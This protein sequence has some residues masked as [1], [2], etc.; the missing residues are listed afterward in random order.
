MSDSN[1]EI[2]RVTTG[3]EGLDVITRGGLPAGRV[4]L[5]SGGTGAGK[6]VLCGQ[7]IAVGARTGNPGIYVT[8]EEPT[9][10]LVRNFDALG[11][12]MSGLLDEGKV[13]FVDASP[14]VGM[15]TQTTGG[16]DLSGLL[17]RVKAAADEI[18]AERVAL[19]STSAL[20]SQLGQPEALRTSLHHLSNALSEGGITTVMTS[21]QSGGDLSRFGLEEF[22]SDNVLLLTGAQPGGQRRTIQVIKMRGADHLEGPFPL[23]IRG[24]RGMHVITLASAR[25]HKRIG[26]HRVGTGSSGVDEMLNGGLPQGAILLVSGATGTGKTLVATH[27]TA[28]G[29]DNDDRTLFLSYEESPDQLISNASGWGYDFEGAIDSDKLRMISEYPEAATLEDHLV[30]ITELIDDW[31]PDRLVV[32]TLSALE[33]IGTGEGFREFLIGL[34]AAIRESGITALLTSHSP[35]MGGVGVTESHVSAVT[36]AIVLLRYVE[37]PGELQRAIAILKMRGGD[38]DPRIRRFTITETGMNVGEPFAHAGVL[39]AVPPW[40]SGM[41]QGDS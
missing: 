37:A 31:K 29:I 12:G 17:A 13:R 36:D 40:S 24:G 16:Y 28:G 19:D 5:V 23:T 4:T 33:R 8:C 35:I 26:T 39:G 1:D 18:G 41:P 20:L 25:L 22:V 21:E 32:D 3:V 38:H 9:R 27:F 30:D 7:F 6:T 15:E 11:L 14:A 34:T 10:K 2:G